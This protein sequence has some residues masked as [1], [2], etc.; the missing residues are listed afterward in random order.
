MR[1]ILIAQSVL[2]YGALA[3]AK[4]TA[5]DAMLSFQKFFR[6]IPQSWLIGC[7]AIV[8]VVWLLTR[9]RHHP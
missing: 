9:P 6:D 3:S 8:F 2:E 7:T 5:S 1:A 4:A